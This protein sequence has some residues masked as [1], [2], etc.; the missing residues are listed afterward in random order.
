MAALTPPFFN[1]LAP[2]RFP[3]LSPPYPEP[4]AGN[5]IVQITYLGRSDLKPV[6]LAQ[7][8]TTLDSGEESAV[9]TLGGMSVDSA[10]RVTK[11][12]LT[13]VPGRARDSSIR[14]REDRGQ[15]SG[16]G[17][18][19]IEC[20][21]TCSFGDDVGRSKPGSREACA[22]RRAVGQPIS[23]PLT[24]GT[25]QTSASR[26]LAERPSTI[27]NF[28]QPGGLL[29]HIHIP[30]WPLSEHTRQLACF[31]PSPHE[32]HS[33]PPAATRVPQSLRASSPSSSS[34]SR[35]RNEATTSPTMPRTST[36]PPRTYA[37]FP[38]SPAASQRKA[39]HRLLPQHIHPRT[40]ARTRRL[41]A[42]RQPPSGGSIR[43][44]HGAARS[45]GAHLQEG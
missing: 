33:S 27:S 17:V 28:R 35:P 40:Q 1:D 6:A 9:F 43:R 42:G 38:A 37:P 10:R 32:A 12:I 5:R 41:R 8:M 31:V 20:S 2:S 18:A 16:S 7:P 29:S 14:L 4:S 15:L 21:L 11:L 30:P 13:V 3:L 45:H 19:A 39:N 26:R 34:P 25:P 22:F 24:L 36:K 23:V 44:A